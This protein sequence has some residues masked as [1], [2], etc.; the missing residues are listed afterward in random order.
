MRFVKVFS[1]FVASALLSLGAVTALLHFVFGVA[2]PSPLPVFG[3]FWQQKT[4]T[5][6]GISML[7]SLDIETRLPVDKSVLWWH[8][9]RQ[10]IESELKRN[11]LIQA[12]EIS[13][14]RTLSF[15]CFRVHIAEREPA[16]IALVGNKSWIVGSDGAFMAPLPETNVDRAMLRRG[17]E[18]FRPAVVRGL[19]LEGASPDVVKARFDYIRQSIGSIEGITGRHIRSVDMQQNGEMRVLFEDLD[20]LVT[21]DVATEQ[22]ERLADE[23]LR[24]K[25]LL[26]RLQGKE[27]T[28]KAIDL[29]YHKL[30]VVEFHIQPAS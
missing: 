4:I 23:A 1:V 17:K 18:E 29:A 12:A 24:L 3:S 8:L 21:F 28:I 14:C 6:S 30:G 22:P 5:L 25:T 26:E 11:P 2:L 20:I 10:E 15:S 27:K 19:L 7:D 16:F 9:H 13:R